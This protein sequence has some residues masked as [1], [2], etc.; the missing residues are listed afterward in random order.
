MLRKGNKIKW[1]LE[2]NKSF[3]YIKVVLTKSPVLSILDSTE[4]FILF[5]FTSEH[6]IIDVLL[7]KDEQ[8]FEK[9]K[10]YFSQTLG[11]A[12]LRYYI[13]EK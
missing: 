7:Q 10:S 8:D 6:T 9:P 1:N 11:D 5:S 2:A 13:M 3:E 12:P 4:Y